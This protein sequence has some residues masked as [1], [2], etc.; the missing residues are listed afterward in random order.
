VIVYIDKLYYNNNNNN[1]NEK[2][3]RKNKNQS[4]RSN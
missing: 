2:F 1:I 3:R 4:L